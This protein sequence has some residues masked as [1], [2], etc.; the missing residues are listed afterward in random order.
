MQHQKILKFIKVIRESFH[1]SVIIY[2]WGG[3]FGFYAILKHTYPKAVPY[4]WDDDEDHVIA[5]INGKFYDIT[6]EVTHRVD[7]PIKM[8]KDD[9]Q[10]WDDSKNGQRLEFM[11]AKYN[12]MCK[13]HGKII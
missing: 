6:G 1:D 13:K 5:K 4:F 3:C 12:R 10:H 11:L 9:I 7:E 2:C 8:T